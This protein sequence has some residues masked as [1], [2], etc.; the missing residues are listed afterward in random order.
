MQLTLPDGTRGAGLLRVAVT[1]DVDN[2][3]DERNPGGTAESNNTTTT[4]VTATLPTY[5][6]LLVEQLDVQ[7]GDADWKPGDAVTVSWAVRNAGYRAASGPWQE[8]LVVRNLVTNQVVYSGGLTHDGSVVGSRSGVSRSLVIPW[9]AGAQSQGRFSFTVTVDA[10]GLVPEVNADGTGETNNTATLTVQSASD[11]RPSDLALDPGPVQSGAPLTLRWT[12]N[13]EGNAAIRAGFAERVTVFNNTTHQTLLSQTVL[14]DAVADGAIAAEGQRQRQLTFTLPDGVAGAGNLTI[15]VTSDADNSLIEANPSNTAETNNAAS[16]NVTS[17]VAAYPNLAVSAPVTPPNARGGDTVTV[18]WTVTNV[19]SA[20]ATGNW[21]DHLELS[22]DTAYGGSD[23]RASADVGHQG[24]LAA[25]ASYTASAQVTLPLQFDGT[26]N[27]IVRTDAGNAVLEPDTR[28]NNTSAATP[29]GVTAPFSDLNVEVVSAP[30]AAVAGTQVEIAW[31]VRNVGDTPATGSWKDRLVLSKDGV[32]DSSDLVLATV[33]HSGPLAPQDAYTERQTITLPVDL[34]GGWIV[35]VK[36]D[37]DGSVYEGPRLGNNLGM[38]PAPLVI[39]PAPAADLVAS[40]V[41]A[42]AQALSGAPATVTWSVTNAG[43]ADATGSW[44]DYV[45]LSANG[46]LAGAT[47]LGTRVRNDALAAGAHYDASLQV[48]LPEWADTD[49]A[50]ILFVTDAGNHVYESQREA[51]NQAAAAQPTALRHVNLTAAGLDA[52]ASAASGDAVHVVLNVAQSGSTGLNGS[53][54]DR[55][56]LSQTPTLTG[57]SRLLDAKVTSQVLAAGGGYQVAFDV[58]LPVDVQGRWYLVAVTDA[59][60][61]IKEVGSESDNQV[62][63]AIDVTLAPYADLVVSNVTAPTRVIADPARV[64][65][66]WTVGNAGTGSGY[67]GSWTDRVVLSTDDVI[68]NGDDIVLGNFAHEGGLA[69][70]QSYSRTETIFAPASYRPDSYKVFVLTDATGQVFENGLEANNRASAATTLDLMPIPYADL[71]LTDISA[72]QTAQ[73]GGKLTVSWSVANQGIAVTNT[74]GWSDVV[75][76]SRNPDGSAPFMNVGFDHLG[77]LAAG[78]GYSRTGEITLPEDLSGTV[79]V[80]VRTNAG[81]QVFEFTHNDAGNARSAGPV[82]VAQSPSADLKVTAISAPTAANEGATVDITWTVTNDGQA[83]ANG[84]WTDVISLRKTGADPSDPT[85]PRPIYLGSF[86]T[87]GPLGAGL[88]YTRTERI[89]LPARIEG[90]WQVVVATDTGNSVFEGSPE[91]D[92]NTRV[93]NAVTVLSLLPRPDL[94]VE[95]IDSPATVTAGSSASVSFVVVNRG[96][97]PTSTPH[98]VDKVYFSLNNKLD[99]NDILLATV[100][101]GSALDPNGQYPSTAASFVLPER[102]RGPGYFIVVTDADGAVDEYPSVN[103]SNNYAVKP[104]TI[105]AQPLADLVMSA[106]VAPTQGV[107]GGEVSVTYT[108][109]NKGSAATSIPNWTDSVWL[110]KDKTRPSPG[111][112]SVLSADGTPIVIPGND[113]VL[114]GSFGHAGVLAVGESYTQTVKVRLPQ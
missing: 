71:V 79:Y 36:S 64:T 19:G 24:P 108:V 40:Q 7:P 87:S 89:K 56:Y 59:K 48:Q 22:A 54:T 31:R 62:S 94:Q 75:S 23:T 88:S 92:N 57:T 35:L 29:I 82:Q 9:P 38:A 72:Q 20:A 33:T 21:V 58:T 76:L 81:G 50:Q 44:T 84:N 109:T 102:L 28:A 69:A 51:N 18:S 66:G 112:R 83:G 37:L 52:P 55:L 107:Y 16:L 10:G 99:S 5:A 43:E 93:N 91:A 61:E 41:V 78:A 6:D 68:G 65:V 47:L 60:A 106:V 45:Y 25:G 14:Y 98:W 90:G 49:T 34:T 67:T 2:A 27:W 101:N 103:E 95:S 113:A 97:V 100:P 70:G 4:Q 3:L 114:L 11:V 104:V 111:A 74:T 8:T 110:S 80:T 39:A 77:S 85:S 46:Q 42:P 73:S 13:N 63:R 17:A 96:S 12:L 53:W 1:V 86:T 15:T 105:T 30:A 26:L 32:I